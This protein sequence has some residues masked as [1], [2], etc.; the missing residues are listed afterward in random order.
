M[1]FFEAVDKRYS[2]KDKFLPD[3]VPLEHL[4]RIA[5]SGLAAPTGSNSQ[6]VRLVI[7]PDREAVQPL[8]DLSPHGGLMTAPAVIAV[9]TDSSTQTGDLNFELEDYA[10]ATENMLL[11]AVAL[12]YESLWLDYPYFDKD[13]ENAALEILGAPATHRL[14]VVLPIGLPDGEGSR[15][16]KLPFS[17]RVSYRKF[18]Q[19]K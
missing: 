15:R 13:T 12:G 8:S 6:C 14:R 18:G 16:E 9:L 3:P 5:K 19:G 1:D 11:A 7:L 4:E 10:A 2:H 17:A